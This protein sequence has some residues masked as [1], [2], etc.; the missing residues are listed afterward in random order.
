MERRWRSVKFAIIASDISVYNG[1]DIRLTASD[2]HF[3][4]LVSCG[5]KAQETNGQRSLPCEESLL[6]CNDELC[7]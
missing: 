4:L 5:E 7:T 1:S 2:I 3:A 6:L